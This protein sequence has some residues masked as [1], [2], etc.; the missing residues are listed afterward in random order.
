MLA[1][2]ARKFLAL[3]RQQWPD[4]DHASGC[5]DFR[6]TL[7]AINEA[8]VFRFLT[9]PQPEDVAFCIKQAAVVRAAA[10]RERA[11]AARPRPPDAARFTKSWP[12]GLPA[13]RARARTGLRLRGAGAQRRRRRHTCALDLIRHAERLSAIEILDDRIR[14]AAAD[15]ENVP[16][17]LT[18]VNVHP[19]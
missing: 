8:H 17:A 11:G 12:D 4:A 16:A 3:V 2:A 5:T 10:R 14:S 15:L 1:P 18:L 9:K 7:D 6:A 19:R 13:D